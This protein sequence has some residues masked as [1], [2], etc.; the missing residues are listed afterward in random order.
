VSANAVDMHEWI[1]NFSDSLAEQLEQ[2]HP[3]AQR[4]CHEY[5][6]E[7]HSAADAGE[8][9]E[10]ARLITLTQDKIADELIWEEDKLRSAADPSYIP[11]CMRHG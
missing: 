3:S 1:N 11:R 6:G 2:I 9:D 5:L 4:I 10:L 8:M 7:M